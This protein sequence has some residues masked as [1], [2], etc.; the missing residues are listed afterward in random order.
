MRRGGDLAMTSSSR[1]DAAWHKPSGLGS[2]D[3]AADPLSELF[4]HISP[5]SEWAPGFPIGSGGD[6]AGESAT[7]DVVIPSFHRG[8]GGPA[9]HGV[10]SGPITASTSFTTDGFSNVTGDPIK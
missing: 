4:E 2:F 7:V 3:S 8:S 10:I 6:S 1:F 9:P 5:E